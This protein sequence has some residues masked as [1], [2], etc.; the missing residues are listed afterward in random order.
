METCL[1]L[2]SNYASFRFQARASISTL[3][4]KFHETTD[5]NYNAITPGRIEGCCRQM[6]DWSTPNKVGVKA[7]LE[8]SPSLLLSFTAVLLA[9]ASYLS[10][11]R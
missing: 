9:H 5:Q 8:T 2:C 4:S 7:P 10:Y 1:K 6:F 3:Q 11:V